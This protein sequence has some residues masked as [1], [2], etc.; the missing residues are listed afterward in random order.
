MTNP[1]T[2]A[3]LPLHV[4]REMR[5]WSYRSS[6]RTLVFRGFWESADTTVTE[7][8]CVSV[9]AMKTGPVYRGLTIREAPHDP[10]IAQLVDGP[11]PLSPRYHRLQLLSDGQP[12]GFVVC[13]DVR[14]H[15]SP[16]DQW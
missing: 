8:E 16:V 10:E 14:L 11:E 6:H 9:V 15:E 3:P 12:A 13:G 7:V 1:P 4:P 5:V 2:T